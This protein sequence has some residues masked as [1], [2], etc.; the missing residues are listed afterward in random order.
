[1]KLQLTK[2]KLL[3]LDLLCKVKNEATLVQLE[4][5]G[6]ER[7]REFLKATQGVTVPRLEHSSWGR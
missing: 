6:P 4:G 2:P 1:M 5:W 3:L 7:T